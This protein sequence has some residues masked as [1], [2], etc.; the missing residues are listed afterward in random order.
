MTS[1]HLP[2]ASDLRTLLLPSGE[3]EQGQPWRLLTAW[4]AVAFALRA[5]VALG[6]DFV[7]HPDEIMQYLEPA[8]RAVFGNGI[9]F[10][11]FQYGGR[12]WIVPGFVASILWLHDY[13]GLGVPWVYVYVVKLVFCAIS[14]L[15]PWGAYHLARRVLGEAS[16]RTA[17]I[18]V[19]LWPYL[20]VF[21]HK[22]FTEFLST[23]MLFG[24]LGLA[25]RPVSE[26]KKSA[27]AFGAI[28]ALV[29]AV[30]MQYLPLALLVWIARAALANRA[31]LLASAGGVAFVIFLVGLIETL[32]WGKPFHSY[33]SN[34]LLNIELDKIRTTQDWH[35]YL[36]RLLYATAGGVLVMLYAFCRHPRRHMLVLLMTLA[37]IILHM[38]LGHKEFRFVFVLF[39]LCLIVVGDQMA[40]WSKR[41]PR[42]FSQRTAVEIGIVSLVV[43]VGNLVDDRWLHKA[44]SYERGDAKY[45]IGQGNMFDVYLDL[46]KLE[47]VKGVLHVSDPYFN[48]PGYYYL[49][50]DVP[51]YDTHSFRKAME[52]ADSPEQ[53]F[54]H[55]VSIDGQIALPDLIMLGGVGDEYS[56]GFIEG[57]DTVRLWKSNTPNTVNT[58]ATRMLSDVLGYDEPPVFEFAQ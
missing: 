6:G 5:V 27:F 10:W 19:C 1:T 52:S 57:V 26:L 8:H 32:T 23:S 39:P 24:A 9:V 14:L 49:H 34:F 50:H 29:G 53:L 40:M 35:F 25:C 7:L 22:P 47:D 21:A 2:F 13:V 4:L 31:W 37:T 48:T 16:A 18:L 11:E 38:S 58:D 46:A 45:L 56:Y 30:R 20:V 15:V 51:L 44:N 42:L 41:W 55:V 33:Y 3:T 54:S 36:P 43:V 17:L 12:S 28:L